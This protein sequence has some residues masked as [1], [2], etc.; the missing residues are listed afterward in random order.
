[1]ESYQMSKKSYKKDMKSKITN[2]F[3]QMIMIK[4]LEKLLIIWKILE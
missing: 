2:V 4:L 3:R 1:M